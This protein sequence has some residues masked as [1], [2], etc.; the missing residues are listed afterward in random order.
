METMTLSFGVRPIASDWALADACTVRA[1]CY[2]HHLPA[3]KDTY[4]APDPMDESGSCTS[5]LAFDKLSGAPLGTVRVQLSTLGPLMLESSYEV[6]EWMA[7]RTRAELTR[8]SVLPGADPLVRLMLW[9]AGY[10]YCL[11]NQIQCMVIGA[12]RP[13]LIRQ[14]QGL[15]FELLTDE[16]V[17]FAHAGG[18]PHSVLWF[19]VRAA[20]R[21]WFET[22][23]PLYHFMF[24]THHP[25]LDLFGPRWRPDVA[26]AQSAA[27]S[28]SVAGAVSSEVSSQ[29]TSIA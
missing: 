1:K 7:P 20:E 13:A 28:E 26:A 23:H 19:D 5:F 21:R 29:R 17:L 16:P 6:P 9:K 15:G 11:A 24:T 27:R 14:Y 8:L 10:Y 3:L 4:A 2:G 18:L 12:R 25:D 22:D